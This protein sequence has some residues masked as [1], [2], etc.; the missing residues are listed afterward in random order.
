[1]VRRGLRGDLPEANEISLKYHYAKNNHRRLCAAHR[2]LCFSHTRGPDAGPIDQF[3]WK[4][5]T[6]I[7]TPELA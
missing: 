5:L 4:D 2:K 1:M 3:G 7:R 6:M